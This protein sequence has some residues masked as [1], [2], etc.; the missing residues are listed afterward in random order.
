MHT[1]SGRSFFVAL[2][3][4]AM[5]AVMLSVPM[6]SQGQVDNT[7]SGGY[8]LSN[9]TT[10]SYNTADGYAAML[11]NSTGGYNTAIGTTTLWSNTTGISNTATGFDALFANTTGNY[12][13]AFGSSA[14]YLNTTGSCNVANGCGAGFLN[15][16][17]WYNTANG[18][19]ALSGNTTGWYNTATGA[20]ALDG[21]STGSSNT[22]TGVNALHVNAGQ[23]NTATGVGAL[24]RNTTGNNNTAEGYFALLNSTTGS[25]NI[26]LGNGAGVNVITGSNNILI[27]NE[28]TNADSGVIR[29]G[30]PGTQGSTYIAGING[31]TASGGVPVYITASGQLGTITSSRRFKYDIQDLGAS[32]EKLMDLRPVTF[33]YKEAAED[34]SHPLQ[35]G[36]IAEEVAKVYPDL[37]QY[38]KQ[39]KPFTVYYH[40]L[41][42][43]MLKE[44]QK[45]HQEISDLKAGQQNQSVALQS[46]VTSLQRT[47]QG[48]LIGMG[49]FML[50]ALFGTAYV[51]GN[52]SRRSP[53]FRMPQRVW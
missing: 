2:F 26:A 37:V 39:G 21:N 47:V 44:L 1:N 48:L 46:Q 42:P 33:R 7:A 16:T 6:A 9:N 3:C 10:G 50:L 4:I 29:I 35:Y 34:G 41:T 24:F 32:S 22:A 52:R 12:N 20:G 31:V 8:A 38:D 43:I 45:A 14:L 49:A 17:G 30:T 36:L 23:Y 18:Y 19:Y 25:Y 15:T 53:V 5:A 11:S 27:G 51:V 28:G 13:A 40:L